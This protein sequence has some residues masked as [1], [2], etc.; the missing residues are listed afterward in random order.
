MY[1]NKV[2]LT[3][4]IKSKRKT[5]REGEFKYSVLTNEKDSYRAGVCAGD[6]FEK[7]DFVRVEGRLKYVRRTETRSPHLLI[8]ATSIEK[9]D[10]NRKSENE[11]VLSGRVSSIGTPKKGGSGKT[12]RSFMID[13]GGGASIPCSA[14]GENV[15]KLRKNMNLTVRGSLKQRTVPDWDFGERDLQEVSIRRWKRTDADE[16]RSEKPA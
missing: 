10:S 3:G 2:W 7:G 12:Y 16:N 6:G 1:G 5:E 4:I 15:K 13:C 14:T 11:T 9:I 8:K